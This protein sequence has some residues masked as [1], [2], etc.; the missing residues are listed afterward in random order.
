MWKK[1]WKKTIFL[2]LKKCKKKSKTIEYFSIILWR[3][4][5]KMICLTSLPTTDSPDSKIDNFLFKLWIDFIEV[6]TK[7]WDS[8]R[9]WLLYIRPLIKCMYLLDKWNVESQSIWILV[10]FSLPTIVVLAII[11]NIFVSIRTMS[12]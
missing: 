12:D 4:D 6:H 11:F 3:A 10:L 5:P 9:Y 8:V 2:M 7:Y 1:C